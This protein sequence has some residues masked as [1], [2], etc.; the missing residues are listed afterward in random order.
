MGHEYN[1]TVHEAAEFV[2]DVGMADLHGYPETPDDT[3]WLVCY[4][5]AIMLL[6]EALRTKPVYRQPVKSSYPGF[7][8]RRK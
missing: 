6:D 5:E 3:P 1:M 7:Y 4:R 8:G 2:R